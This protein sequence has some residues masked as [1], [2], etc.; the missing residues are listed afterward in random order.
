MLGVK[1]INKMLRINLKTK[2]LQREVM[3]PQLTRQFIG[4]NGVALKL[5]YDEV[6]PTVGPFDPENKLI[7]AAAPFNGTKLP[8]S[9][10]YQVSAR[11]P[12][13][14]YLISAQANGYFG[15]RLRHAGL[16]TLILE[17]QA[18]E[19][20]Y[21]WIHDGEVEPRS[22]AHLVGK[23]C[24]ETEEIL[25]KEIGGRNTSVAC[26]GPAGENLVPYACI[27][28]DEGHIIATN[29]PGAVMGAKKVKAVVVSSERTE[30]DTWAD[31]GKEIRA[32]L[33]EAAAASGL[34]GMVKRAGTMGYFDNLPGR[35]GMPTKNYTTNEFDYSHYTKEQ[36]DEW[37][38][39]KKTTCWKCPWAHT[40]IVT[41]KKGKA[42]GFVGEEPEY[43]PLAGF[44]TNIGNTDMGE[45]VRLC[46]LCEAWGFDGKELSFL[47]S[48]LFECYNKGLVTKEDTGG[49]D[50]TWGNTDDVPQLLENIACRKG[51]KLYESLAKG[52]KG[53]CIDIGGEALN[54]GIYSG[55]GL[56]PNVVDERMSLAA[57]YNLCLSE[58]G[59]F[60][61]F[62]SADPDVGNTGPI[63]IIKDYYK[64]GYYLAKNSMKWLLMD[65]YGCCFFYVCGKIGPTLDALNAATGWDMSKEELWECGE[66]IKTLSRAY[67]I[68]CGLTKEIEMSVSPRFNKAYSDGPAKGL[69]D[70]YNDERVY[71]GY[72]ER[73]GWDLATSKPLPQTLRRLGLTYI[74]RDIWGDDVADAVET[75]D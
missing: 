15:A 27:F 50:F 72:Y 40:G 9:G 45:G 71:N 10:T 75:T 22:A 8:G 31:T 35:G 53:A 5:L 19:W 43:E 6:P 47:I 7:F 69:I 52:V 48:M 64:V 55:R 4:G 61:G 26:I 29:G 18:D 34:G 2:E 21:I 63:D 24:W 74:I 56:A 67:N 13:T 1:Y 51:G 11:G 38:D 41:I 28:S 37:W 73:S 58:T 36:R 33:V 70:N 16:E 12:L 68:R 3:D 32:N 44:T 17:D 60:Y 39:K 59:S 66:R 65:A 46:Y 54:M 62:A 30:V 49:L 25:L 23:G 14:N 57:F 42:K 20:I